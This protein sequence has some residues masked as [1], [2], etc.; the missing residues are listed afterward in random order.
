VLALPAGALLLALG[1]LV[2]A[3]TGQVPSEDARPGPVTTT[4]RPPFRDASEV[5][6]AL[7]TQGEVTLHRAGGVAGVCLRR[8]GTATCLANDRA[9]AS[10]VKVHSLLVDGRWFVVAVTAGDLDAAT[11]E[12]RRSGLS[13]GMEQA[14]VDRGGEVAIGEVPT[15]I[16]TVRLRYLD[17]TGIHTTR[18]TRPA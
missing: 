14:A 11:L 5:G 4:V 3:G 8:R 7:T 10:P 15:G 1:A 9:D 16:G 6:A 13:L 2:V 12:S 17:A 18:L